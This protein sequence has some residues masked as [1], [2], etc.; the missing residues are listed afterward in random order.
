MNACRVAIRPSSKMKNRKAS[1]K[2]SAPERGE[3]EQHGQPTAH[4]QEQQVAGED[5]GEESYR[6]RDQ[7]HEVRDHLDHEDAALPNGFMSSRPGGSQL[8]K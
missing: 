2:V 5:V 3:A 1:G 4:E 7:A 6:E 8:L